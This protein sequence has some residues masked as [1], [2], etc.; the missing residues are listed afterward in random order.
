MAI[1]KKTIY[2]HQRVD[3]ER[4]EI[5]V[6]DADF[7][8]LD[9]FTLLATKEVEFDVGDFD[10]RGKEIEVVERALEQIRAESQSKINLL[11]DRLSKL[12]AIGHESDVVE[13]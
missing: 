6:R 8:V 5:T 11:L 3:A 7:S 13:G 2:L 4:S 9:N 10:G 1:I 12:K